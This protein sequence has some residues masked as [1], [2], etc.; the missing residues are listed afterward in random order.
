MSSNK[1]KQKKHLENSS[2][3]MILTP[4]LYY[5]NVVI[6]LCKV[7]LSLIGQLCRMKFQAL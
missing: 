1:T 2:L 6:L 4:K 5:F 7:K 3:F